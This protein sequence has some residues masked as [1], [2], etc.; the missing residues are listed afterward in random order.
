[1]DATLETNG[2][3]DTPQN[4]PR[5]QPTLYKDPTMRIVRSPHHALPRDSARERL[6]G[7]SSIEALSL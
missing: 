6:S 5:S 2:S 7:F 4:G 1:M 3:G